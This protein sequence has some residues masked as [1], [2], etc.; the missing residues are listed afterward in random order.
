MENNKY[1]SKS[2]TALLYYCRILRNLVKD[3][4]VM[5]DFECGMYYYL[6]KAENERNVKRMQKF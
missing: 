5:R 6:D 1:E 2:M 4:K 3:T